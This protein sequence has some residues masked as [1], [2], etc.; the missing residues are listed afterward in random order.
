MP[1]DM[2]APMQ[3]RAAP[4]AW[5]RSAT[6]AIRGRLRPHA[7][8]HPHRDAPDATAHTQALLDRLSIATQAAGI[9]CWELDWN[10]Y[11]IAW[12]ASRLPAN[13]VAAASRRHFG[14]ELGSDL[15]KWVHPE[16]QH[17][18]GKAMTESLARGEDHVSFRYR[19]VLP[20]NS[21][22]HVQAFARTYTEPGGKPQRSIGVSWDITQEVEATERLA[23]DSA[24]KRELL[25][26]LSVATQAAGLQCWEYDFA[27][28]K[29]TW[30]DYNLDPGS[31][32]AESVQQAG[33]ALYALILP[34][35]LQRV[36]DTANAAMARHEPM[37]SARY[38]RRDP[39]GTLHYVQTYQRFFYDA[40]GKPARTLGA[41]VDISESQRRQEELEALSIRFEIATRAAQA[42]LWEWQESNGELWWNDTMYAIYG[43]T[44]GDCQLTLAGAI[45]AIH[46]D[47]VALAQAAWDAAL[48]DAGQLHVQF[49][50]LRPDRSIAHV[51][52]LA[53]VVTDPNSR[54]R[55]LVGITLDVS[56]RA[57]A[58]QR[59]RLLQKQ[60]RA[61]SH[62]SGMAEVATGVL[63][64]V[65]NVLNSLGVSSSTAQSRLR[66][67][68]LERVT[69]VAELLAEHRDALGEF[70]NGNARG[71]LLPEYLST[72][73]AQLQKDASELQAEM[74][75][76]ADHVRYLR[77]IVQT[78]Q[79]AARSAGAAELVSV[80]ELVEA[81]IALRSQELRGAHITR[82]IPALPE[83]LTDRYKLLQIII[84]FVANACDAVSEQQTG[85][86]RIIVRAR[87]IDEQI[88][89]AVE[90]SGVGI[91][92]QLLP[93]VWE[94]GFTTKA[95]GHGFGLHSSAVAAQ[96]LGGTVS[97]ASDGPGQGARF[98]VR[99]PIRAEASATGEA[100]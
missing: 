25:E 48:Q 79:S 41:N 81:A 5:L 21:I 36:I 43:L 40:H 24:V 33:D 100:A 11:T 82:D 30:L 68:Q 10:T 88:E 96:Q 97:A 27:R 34:E 76:I 86:Q 23:R 39:D 20:D 18:G 46:P 80:R 50:I 94:F 60:L 15:F 73:G 65:G 77:E 62:Q 92:A 51:D 19:L 17:A 31:A 78:Q 59:E 22:R 52:T 70:L 49:R 56:Q 45:A 95:R 98:A 44:R 90:D 69:R 71:R 9:Y 35:D 91:A 83:V 84:N 6:R 29:L 13:E 8:R 61:A 57:F 7:R 42:G 1:S 67:L 28:A 38:R 64:N 75:A 93:R 58:E 37:I 12:D 74:G 99:I 47:D 89:I 72:L 87:E 32:S 16:D 4:W 55:R 14:F 66:T 63:H 54:Q 3:K 53:V 26:R 85:E 2:P